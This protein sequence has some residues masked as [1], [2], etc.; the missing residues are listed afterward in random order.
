M[1][2]ATGP[3]SLSRLLDDLPTLRRLI[4][5]ARNRSAATDQALPL[6]L[7]PALAAHTRMQLLPDCLLLLASNNSVAQMLRFHGPRLA[8]AAAVSRFQVRVQPD[9]F[10]QAAVPRASASAGAAPS[11]S[12]ASAAI[13][14]STADQLEPGELA[15]ALRR[16]A[17]CADSP[18]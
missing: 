12:P 1:S 6:D 17:A 10:G 8:K 9:Q 4:C 3:Q 11:L 5:D 2:N 15:D 18:D 16:L 13:L 14:A 7:P